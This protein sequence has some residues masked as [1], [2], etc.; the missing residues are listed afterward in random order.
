MKTDWYS[1][2]N[3]LSETD[4]ERIRASVNDMAERLTQKD[5]ITE[6]EFRTKDQASCIVVRL[7]CRTLYGVPIYDPK[8]DSCGL[9]FCNPNLSVQDGQNRIK[10][11]L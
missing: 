5:F 4:K 2:P 8:D 1:V 6:D 3:D 11:L 7:Q 9:L 10:G